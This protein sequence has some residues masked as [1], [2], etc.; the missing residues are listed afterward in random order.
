MADV[1]YVVQNTPYNI[2]AVHTVLNI[3]AGANQPIA[4]IEWGVS[5]DGITSNAIPAKVELCQSTQAAAGTVGAGP[6][7]I[8]QAGGRVIAPQFTAQ[9]NYTVEPTV[10]S[11]IE[12]CYIPQFNG[13]YVKQYPLGQ[14]PETD[15]SGGTIKAL[16]L[17][18][19][20]SAAV[21]CLAY[22]RVAIGG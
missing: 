8:L 20:P 6:P 14:E 12:P 22:A 17:R 16:C 1:T 11:C 21:N 4:I 7:A 10:L 5:F 19:T 18:V 9:H 3:I 13:A 2:S 15:L